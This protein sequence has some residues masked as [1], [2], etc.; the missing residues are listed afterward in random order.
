MKLCIFTLVGLLLC[1][2]SADVYL[3]NPRGSNNRLNEASTARASANRMFDSQNNNNGGYNVGDKDQASHSENDQFNMHYFQSSESHKS[4]SPGLDGKS[5]LTIE[6]TNQH[7]CGDRDLNCNIVLQ[8]KCQDDSAHGTLNYDSLRNGGTTSTSQYHHQQHTSRSSKNN[9]KQSDSQ[10]TY[11]LHEPWEWYD[12]CKKRYRNKGLF[13]ADQHLNGDQ[14]IYTRQNPNGNRYGYECPEERDYYPYW[15]PTDWIDIAV[16]AHNQSMCEYYRNESFNVKEKGECLQYYNTISDGFRH[17]SMYNNKLDCEKKGGFWVQFINYL[18]KK[19]EFDRKTDCLAASTNDVRLIWAIPYRSEDIDDLRMSGHSIE[20]L[21]RC[22]VA[23]DPPECYKAPYTRSNHL[24]NAHNVVPL[25]Y[26]WVLPYF[27][28][29]RAQRCVFRIRYN[30]STGDYPPFNTFSD[31]NHAQNE[32][33][34]SPVQNNPTVDIGR[35]QL[36]LRL[37]INTAQFG[38]TFQDRS[39]LFKLMPRRTGI[40][41]NDVIYN[42]NVRGKR[43]NIVQVYPAVEYDFIPKRL[44]ITNTSLV[45]IQWTGSN[46]NPSNNDGQGTAG[47][48][49]NNM[50]EM[51]DP[52]VNYP[53][54]SEKTLTMFENA[55]IVWSSDIETKSKEDLI[56]S[57]ASSGYY[58]SMALCY[59]STTDRNNRAQLNVLLNNAPASYRG[60]LLRFAPGK[61]YYMCTRNNNFSNRNQKGRLTVI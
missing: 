55:E 42:L 9:R 7:G 61:Y 3:H 41:N 31:Q 4:S 28:S 47:T 46:R 30:I 13:T 37:A 43:G 38:R 19:E 40:T 35:T 50:V 49:R 53:L 14:S 33:V 32:G 10:T 24:G 48:D 57:M 25:N 21:R 36:Q 44:K 56:I 20:S 16:L 8:Y 12:K 59:P 2:S 54:T 23:L 39:H 26:T 15:H 34:Y 11:G 29:R 60:M 6:W 52:S 45:H 22:L 27:P 17:D 5:L 1:W 58:N 18:E 51:Q